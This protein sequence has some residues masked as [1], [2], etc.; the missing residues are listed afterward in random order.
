VIGLAFEPPFFLGL[1]P[2]FVEYAQKYIG[3][4]YIGETF[5]L[6]KPFIEGYTYMWHCNLLKEIPLKS[7][8][9]SIMVSSKNWAPGHKY[10]HDLVKAILNSRLPIDIYG[11]G[12]SLYSNIRDSRLKGEFT[13]HEPY[14]SYSFHIAIENYQTNHYFSEKV[15]NPLL[16]SVVPVYLGC[17]NIDHYF[18][19]MVIPMSGNVSE[20]IALFRAIIFNQNT[21]RKTIDVSLVE[22]RTNL[23]LHLD[24]IFS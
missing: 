5:D 3:K 8:V 1:S 7:R 2:A 19:N 10:R 18:P 9:M 14:E 12:C 20:D 24:E 16:C 23:L 15:V 21:Y 4:Y 17:R 22:K 13:E 11:N 6:P